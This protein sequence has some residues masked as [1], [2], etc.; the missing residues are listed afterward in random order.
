MIDVIQEPPE[1]L[2]VLNSET[3]AANSTKSQLPIIVK[4]SDESSDI[5][6]VPATCVVQIFDLAV[7]PIPNCPVTPAIEP[8]IDEI[9]SVNNQQTPPLEEFFMSEDSVKDLLPR[10]DHS[11]KMSPVLLT[12]L[13]KLDESVP[14][15]I[16]E[17]NWPN[18]LI[19]PSAEEYVL[20]NNK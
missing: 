16:S 15:V 6:P 3:H 5:S 13:S 8:F 7:P 18:S 17:T 12:P 2:I 10:S 11:D 4:P 19:L 20:K 1:I 14:N 9:V